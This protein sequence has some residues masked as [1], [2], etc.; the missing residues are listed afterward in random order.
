MIKL[1]VFV[2]FIV[3][4]SVVR[5]TLSLMIIY[6]LAFFLAVLSGVPLKE[7]IMRVWLFIPFFLA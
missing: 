3:F 6:G 4:A 7:F 5:D 1:I 2:L